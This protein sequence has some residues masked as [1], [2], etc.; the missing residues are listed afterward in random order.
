[1]TGWNCEI[2]GPESALIIKSAGT[3]GD[4]HSVLVWDSSCLAQG[5]SF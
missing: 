1:M 3:V 5:Y 4:L 2:L